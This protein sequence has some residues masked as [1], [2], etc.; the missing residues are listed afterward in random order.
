MYSECECPK[1]ISGF[2]RRQREM[3]S[4]IERA[5]RKFARQ[6]LIRRCANI[7]LGEEGKF[8]ERRQPELLGIEALRP[9]Y[10]LVVRGMSSR[11]TQH[12]LE[13]LCLARLEGLERQ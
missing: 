1:R 3:K 12:L 8:L 11:V 13:A 7:R 9:E 4:S 10:A 2:S 6:Y 5:A